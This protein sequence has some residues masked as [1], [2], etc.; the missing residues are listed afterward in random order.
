ME[1]NIKNDEKIYIVEDEINIAGGVEPFI[2]Q[3]E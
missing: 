3:L 2:V 1:Y